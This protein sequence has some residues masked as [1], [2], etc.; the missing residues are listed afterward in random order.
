MNT[1]LEIDI[2]ALR[3]PVQEKYLDIAVNPGGE[4]LFRTW[5]PSARHLSR[6]KAIPSA[7]LDTTVESFPWVADPSLPGRLS[8]GEQ[9][10]STVLRIV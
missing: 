1:A 10:E 3:Q 9:V 6:D 7:I 5:G 2:G 8:S 4:F